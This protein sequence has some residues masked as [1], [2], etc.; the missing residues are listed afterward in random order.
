[1]NTRLITTYTQLQKKIRLSLLVITSHRHRHKV[2]TVK[3]LAIR[4]MNNN[5]QIPKIRLIL[6]IRGQVVIRILGFER[7]IQHTK[8]RRMLATQIA[9][10]ARLRPREVTRR[11]LATVVRVEVCAGA[12][13][14]SVR[15]DRMRMDMVCFRSLDTSPFAGRIGWE[16]GTY[17]RKYS[18]EVPRSPHGP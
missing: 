18:E 4:R 16:K 11:L 17:A 2:P 8:S 14:V 10:L 3:S 5:R 12:V 1:M 9:D 6:R 15:G 7:L 13:A